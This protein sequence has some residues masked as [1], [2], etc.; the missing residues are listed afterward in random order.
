MHRTQGASSSTAHSC[1]LS[2]PLDSALCPRGELSGNQAS[3]SVLQCPLSGSSEV[4]LRHLELSTE[5][6]TFPS[7]PVSFLFQGLPA[8]CIIP[9]CLHASFDPPSRP[10]HQPVLPPLA[11]PTLLSIPTAPRPGRHLSPALQQLLVLS[12]QC[13]G[14]SYWSSLQQPEGALSASLTMAPC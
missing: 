14:P 11:H 8:Q 2:R 9:V 5:L 1:P 10:I 4:S 12:R 7:P 6:G 3:D 13:S